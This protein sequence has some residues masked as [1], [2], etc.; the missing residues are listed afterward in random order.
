MKGKRW[1]GPSVCVAVALFVGALMAVAADAPDVMTMNSTLWPSHTKALVEFA[2]KKHAEEYKIACTECH[3][4]YEG[5][6]NVWKEGDP[7]QKCQECHNEPTIKGEKK[8]PPEQQKLNL[9]LA[10]HNNCQ[11]CHKKLKAEN[12]QTTAPTTCV[13]CH[14]KKEG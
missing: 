11:G 13:Q 1:F 12:P 3:H 14:P 10:F 9:K 6:Q 4:K 7:V 5:G 8:L 2:H